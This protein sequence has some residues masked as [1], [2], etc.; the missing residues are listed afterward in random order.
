[1]NAD[2]AAKVAEALHQVGEIHHMVFSG[3]DG[4]DDDWA[5]FYAD[6][7]LGHSDLRGYSRAR[8]TAR[9]KLELELKRVAG[10]RRVAPYHVRFRNEAGERGGRTDRESS[11]T[12]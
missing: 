4:N 12:G 7:L 1:M 2:T 9:N 3:T 5:T 6:W 10:A 8:R 11:M